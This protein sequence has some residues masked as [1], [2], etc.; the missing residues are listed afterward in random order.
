MTLDKLF[1]LAKLLA[2]M[3]VD[4]RVTNDL[5]TYNRGKPSFTVYASCFRGDDADPYE[6]STYT[7]ETA[8]AALLSFD[9]A[10]DKLPTV[11][12]ETKEE[13]PTLEEPQPTA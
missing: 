4:V 5:A 6:P 10:L 7:G 3:G 11:K 8:I 1:E 9:A 13:E 12:E 2:P